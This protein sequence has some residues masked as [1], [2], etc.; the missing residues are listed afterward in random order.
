MSSSEWRVLSCLAFHP[1]QSYASSP[2]HPRTGKA[3]GG[4]DDHAEDDEHIRAE[5]AGW[6]ADGRMTRCQTF[7]GSLE[8]A[9]TAF[10]RL[11]DFGKLVGRVQG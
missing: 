11:F 1:V 5:F 2:C 7:I 9:T 4:Q 3:D 8:N 10:N 6:I